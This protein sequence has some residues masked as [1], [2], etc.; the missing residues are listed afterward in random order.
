M[1]QAIKVVT[2]KGKVLTTTELADKQRKERESRMRFRNALR[3]DYYKHR[4][5]GLSDEEARADIMAT[6]EVSKTILNNA[7]NT[8]NMNPAATVEWSA[9]MLTLQAKEETFLDDEIEMLDHIIENVLGK[10]PE[11]LFTVE[12]SDSG[13]RGSTSKKN[14]KRRILIEVDA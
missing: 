12:V 7:L 9:K 14:P 11:E 2:K 1:T 3:N 10:P 6:R 4:S 13:D 8:G 5:H